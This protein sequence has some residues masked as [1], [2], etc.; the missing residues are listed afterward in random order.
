MNTPLRARPG[1]RIRSHPFSLLALVAGAPILR[2]L[3][4]GRDFAGLRD[5]L[6]GAGCP[7]DMPAAV[8]SRAALPDQRYRFTVVGELDK[9]PNLDSPAVFLIGRTLDQAARRRAGAATALA[10]EEAECILSSL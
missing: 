6:L 7:S 10:L 3:H 1:P 9:F 5:Q 8:V 4:P 2:P